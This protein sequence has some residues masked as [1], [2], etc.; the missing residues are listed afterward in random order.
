MTLKS[1][2]ARGLLC[3]LFAVAVLSAEADPRLHITTRTDPDKIGS[4]SPD[5]ATIEAI[6]AEMSFTA[7]PSAGYRFSFWELIASPPVPD[8]V[9][10]A[11]STNGNLVTVKNIESLE[12]LQLV[13]YFS[14]GIYT[15]TFDGNAGILEGVASLVVTNNQVIGYPSF[16]TATRMGYT[17]AGWMTNKVDWAVKKGDPVWLT[18][19]V[20][21]VAKWTANQYQVRYDTNDGSGGSSYKDIFF[22]ENYILPEKDPKRIGYKFEGWFTQS[23]GG[24]EVTEYT[25]LT[26]AENHTLYAHW[27]AGKYQVTFNPGEGAT[28]FP[29][30][31]EDVAYG[32]P[33]GELPNPVREGFEFTGWYT[34]SGTLVTPETNVTTAADHMLYA[35]WAGESY[36]VNQSVSDGCTLTVDAAG[37]FGKSL[38]FSWTKGSKTGYTETNTIAVVTATEGGAVLAAFTNQTY[39]DYTM[40][41]T[42]Y[43]AITISVSS[44]FKP[45][46][47]RVSFESRG[48]SYVDSRYVTYDSTY[49]ELPTP[50]RTGY[51]FDGWF[52]AAEGGAQ[53]TKDTQVTITDTQT[54]YAHWTAKTY[55]VKAETDGACS[56]DVAPTGTFDQELSISWSAGEVTGY[57]NKIDTVKIYAD[58]SGSGEL[59]KTYTMGTNATYTM[60]GNY[61]YSGIVI[62]ATATKT[63]NTYTVKFDANGARGKMNPV[64]CTYDT[65]FDLPKQNCYTNLTAKFLGWARDP[66]ATSAEWS[67]EAQGLV[68]LTAEA[69]GIVT[70]YAVWQDL[71]NDLTH[72]AHGVNVILKTSGEYP[73]T[74]YTNEVGQTSARSGEKGLPNCE[75]SVTVNGPGVLSFLWQKSLPESNL[76]LIS[77]VG[78]STQVYDIG[79]YGSDVGDGWMRVDHTI[80]SAGDHTVSWYSLSKDPAD[81]LLIDKVEWKPAGWVDEPTAADRRDI[82]AVTIENGKLAISFENADSRF[83]YSLHGTNDLTAA[84]ALWPVLFTTNDT[85]TITI[86][87]EVKADEK[88]FFYYLEVH[89]K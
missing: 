55:T 87:P 15:I 60:S 50:T 79:N 18:E 35:H 85:G 3:P 89:S 43:P 73:F 59:L 41:G 64:A 31:K 32:S 37:E 65:A 24:E 47:Y 75:M 51:S 28:V 44:L 2:F 52:T 30:T 70:L 36:T 83:A 6:D 86:K 46:T 4:I 45:N 88:Q 68:N 48:G 81:Y 69:G 9:S 10:R 54:L 14:P 84:R 39:A 27:T 63:P 21:A 29:A 11:V 74:P 57:S 76:H 53:V 38:G 78:S 19:D 61:Y 58:A 25:H 33:Y 23:E 7:N 16:P 42:Y 49:G 71:Q 5:D 1:I 72:A 67:D 80:E 20:T 77:L 13:A 62:K 12:A 17:F 56:V 40:T 26:R 82:S 8:I 66:K 34:S 22:D